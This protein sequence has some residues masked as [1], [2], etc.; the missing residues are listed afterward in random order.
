[1]TDKCPFAKGM[2][3]KTEETNKQEQPK[4]IEHCKSKMTGDSCV[5][6]LNQI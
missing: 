3:I 1:M 2:F 5:A 4:T 6:I